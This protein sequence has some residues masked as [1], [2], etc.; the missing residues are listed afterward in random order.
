MDLE[1]YRVR[2]QSFVAELTL[3]Y[4][5]H[6]AGLDESYEIEPI[7]ARHAELFQRASVEALRD[8]VQAATPESESWRRLSML[9]E[10]ASEGLVGQRSKSIE[11]ELALR[12]TRLSIEVEGERMGFRQSTVIQANEPDADRRG[13]IER[14]RLAVTAAELNP[15]YLELLE[16]QHAIARE[17][18]YQS[19]KTMYAELKRI[20][21]DALHEQ[22][23]AF[24]AATELR[25]PELVDPELR[26]ALGYGFDSLRHADLPRFFRS[27]HEDAWFRAERS[28]PSLLATLREL[29][30]DPEGQPGVVFDTARRP[31]KSP[32]AFCAPVRVPAEVYLV[33]APIGGREDYSA[34]FHEGGHTEHYAHVDPALPFEFRHF[35]DNSV[36]EAYAFLFMHLIDDP[37]WLERHLGIDEPG[38]LISDGRA[39]R[40]SYL[41][42]YCGKLAYERE[43]H[44]GAAGASERL[45][46]RYAQHLGAALQV[47]W[48]TETY[49]ADVDAGFYC[50][51][52]LRAWALETYL[53]AHLRQ[54][55]GPAWF[56]EPEAGGAL[57]DLWA[58]GQRLGPEELLAQLTGEQLR[59]DA[60]LLADLGLG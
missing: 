50:A 31:N 4:Y 39:Q 18:G 34:L 36:T 2:A 55:F 21:L 3:A 46:A 38:P 10:F 48:P 13:A 27:P 43:L 58:L 23:A 8:A 15:L 11:S 28:L 51:C 14:A 54:R 59:F 6:Y 24:A 42:R 52:Y 33:I 5:R 17:L 16:H 9:L 22:T 20:D 37:G 57:R 41:R 25:Y 44:G 56:A 30:L 40:L 60:P 35:G 32:R 45:P 49:L 19:Y 29:G 53:R 7:Y 26:R 12:E 1:A 47:A